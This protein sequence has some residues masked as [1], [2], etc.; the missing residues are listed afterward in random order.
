MKIKR[1]ETFCNE[2]VGFV[3]VTTDSG[4]KGWGQVSPYN[5]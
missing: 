3:C 2:F 5:A 4:H 1:L